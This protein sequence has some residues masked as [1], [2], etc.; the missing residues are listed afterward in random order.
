LNLTL[1]KFIQMKL[2]STL[3]LYLLFSPFLLSAQDQVAAATYQQAESQLSFN[4][5]Q[6]VDRMNVRANWESD[7]QFWYK[8]LV[9]DGVE[10]VYY[11]IKKKKKSTFYSSK[12]LNEMLQEE[13]LLYLPTIAVKKFFLLTKVRWF[14][15]GTGI[16]GCAIWTV[17]KKN[18]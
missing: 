4:T 14:L 13:V 12:Q 1:A 7:D 15:S 6:Y 18:N 10:F 16:Y 5:S 8:V 17:V 2:N 11:D 9:K 3:F